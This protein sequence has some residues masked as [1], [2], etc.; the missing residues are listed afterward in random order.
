LQ[1]VLSN[2]A[3]MTRTENAIGGDAP[4]RLCLKGTA[5]GLALWVVNSLPILSAIL[6]PRPG[7][8]PLWGIRGQDTAQYYVWITAY[9][10]RSRIVDH[11]A[12]WTTDAQ[13]HVPIMWIVA[14]VSSAMGMRA[15][16]AHFSFHLAAYVL[17][18]IA[19]LWFL[20]TFARSTH[21]AFVCVLA[22]ACMLPLRAL[23]FL[24]AL[25]L[26]PTT[27]HWSSGFESFADG[28]TSDGFFQGVSG[29]STVTLGTAGALLGLSLIG[30]SL[31]TT[32][33]RDLYIAAAGIG[34]SALLHPFEFIPVLAGGAATLLRFRPNNWGLQILI[35][36]LPS[37]AA[38]AFYVVSGHNGWLRIASDLNRFDGVVPTVS[39]VYV[40]GLGVIVTLMLLAWR[41]WQMQPG[42]LLLGSYVV[43]CVIATMLPFLP[44]PQH[45]LDGTYYAAA[46]V[47][48][49]QWR[50]IE[51]HLR[52]HHRVRRVT[53]MAAAAVLCLSVIAH[54]GFRIESFRRGLD[55]TAAPAVTS[56]VSPEDEQRVIRVLRRI[57]A[58]GDLL[59]APRE[60]APWF[61]TVPMHSFASHWLF[62]LTY[63]QQRAQADRFF[64]GA[65]TKSEARVLLDVYGVRWIVVP[66]GGPALQYLDHATQRATTPSM[67][68]YELPTAGMVPLPALR[69]VGPRRYVWPAADLA[70]SQ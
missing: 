39:S 48:V 15:D 38:T 53:Y 65:L 29:G 14:R 13:L 24:P 6:W 5:V 26:R 23:V 61:A 63:E 58:E 40:L 49:H 9:S 30:R 19:F 60:Y 66:S 41:P 62:S 50:A 22:M 4:I 37:G 32:R 69:K 51:P 64:A 27:W 56:A 52:E 68:L 16:I 67:A 46:V 2:E 17:A 44:W 35:L 21:D 54:L 7:Y 57:G 55:A 12:P 34:V 3:I 43:A 70:G 25:V 33:P 10:Q 1:E 31:R 28:A 59:L 18:G 11:F 36:G 42:D 20:Q 45:M 8:L 47:G